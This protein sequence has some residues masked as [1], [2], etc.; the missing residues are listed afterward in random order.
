MS[1]HKTGRINVLDYGAQG[2]GA[3]DDTGAFQKALDAAG[4]AGGVEVY[5]PPGRYRFQGSL[6]VPPAIA[7]VGSFRFVPAHNGIRDPG[8]PKPGDDGTTLPT[9]MACDFMDPKPQLDIDAAVKAC[10]VVGNR[11]RH[12]AKIANKATG[13]QIGLNAET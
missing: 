10:I 11:L 9:V 1:T 4:K 3:A 6:D 8:L 7:L 2:D 5:A 12:G 13:A